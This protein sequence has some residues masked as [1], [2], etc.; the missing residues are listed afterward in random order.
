MVAIRK[1]DG[2]GKL[3]GF[4]GGCLKLFK[5]RGEEGR[6]VRG[7]VWDGENNKA[8]VSIMEVFGKVYNF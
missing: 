5:G 3:V 8:G 2:R 6:L 7:F 1:A 4:W